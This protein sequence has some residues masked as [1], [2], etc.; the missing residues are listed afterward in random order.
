MVHPPAFEL[1]IPGS[2]PLRAP[3][4]KP[5]KCILLGF[6]NSFSRGIY[7]I[8]FSSLVPRITGIVVGWVVLSSTLSPAIANDAKQDNIRF[9]Y[10]FDIGGEPSFAI[11]QDRDGF[12]WFSSFFNGLVRYDGTAVKKLKALDLPGK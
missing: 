11:I 10:A 2:L 12:L 3:I 4:C 9:E 6:Y 7:I 8:V 1:K 5:L